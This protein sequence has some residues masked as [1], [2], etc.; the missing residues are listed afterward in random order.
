MLNSGGLL[1]V[2][3]AT[4]QATQTLHIVCV[5]VQCVVY[6]VLVCLMHFVVLLGLI[7]CVYVNFASGGRMRV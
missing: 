2:T 1:G 4:L 7:V 6:N 3:Q 5:C